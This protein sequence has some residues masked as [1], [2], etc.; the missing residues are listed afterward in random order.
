VASI[1]DASM[2]TVPPASDREL[3]EDSMNCRYCGASN[4]E[5]EHR[6]RRCGRRLDGEEPG[7]LR[8]AALPAPRVMPR[9]QQEPASR[10]RHPLQQPLFDD[11]P[12]VPPRVI[13]FESIA[14]GTKKPASRRRQTA[15]PATHIPDPAQAARRNTKKAIDR[16]QG[17]LDFLPPLPQTPRRAESSADAAIYCDDPVASRRRRG[18]AAALD[19][20]VALLGT[21][22]FF[23]VFYYKVGEITFNQPALPIFGAVF[24]L[25]LLFYK[26]LTCLL[27][28]Q[29][30]AMAWMELRLLDFDGR[31]ADRRQRLIRLASSC[32]SVL[33]AGAG[34]LWA[35]VDEERLTWHD[36]MSRTF[37]TPAGDLGPNPS[38]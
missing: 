6:C 10:P 9:I 24:A 3:L 32:L 17:S 27:A 20:L 25:I 2:R 22:T 30:P 12:K 4:V 37:A 38:H 36:H 14:P 29:T 5:E 13:P 18:C 16:G 1:K 19:G 33:P 31:P 8:S 21:A 35:L 23:A 15:V 26:L 28:D 34:L 11:R 7:R